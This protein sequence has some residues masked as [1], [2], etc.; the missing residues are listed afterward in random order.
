MQELCWVLYDLKTI[1]KDGS[2][3]VIFPNKLAD[4]LGMNFLE[5]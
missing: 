2:L 1:V 5:L 4:P 3:N